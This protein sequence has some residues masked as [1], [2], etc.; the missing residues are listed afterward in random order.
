MNEKVDGAWTNSYHQYGYAA[1][2]VKLAVESA[3]FLQKPD[4]YESGID[5]I[6]FVNIEHDNRENERPDIILILNETFYDLSL[7]SNMETDVPYLENIDTLENTIRGYAVVPYIGGSTNCSE[8]ELLTS[9]SLRLM[10]GVTPFN[11]INMKDANT[12]VS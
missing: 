5:N 6:E 12:V 9:N 1:C 10:P 2:T 4:G 8:Y 7:I 11:V 3:N